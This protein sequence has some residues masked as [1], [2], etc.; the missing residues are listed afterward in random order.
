MVEPE[1]AFADLNTAA[2]LAEDLL[3]YC[4]QAVLNEREDD[5]DFF[6]KR[7][8]SD[9]KKRL[10]KFVDSDFIQVDYT[11]AIKILIDSGE[12]FSFPVEWGVD[13]QSEHERYLA[14]THFQAPVI[15]KNYPKGIKSFYMRLNEDGK[16]VAAMDV[17]AP[18]IGEIIGGSQREERLEILDQRMHESGLDPEQYSLVPRSEKVWHSSSCWIWLRF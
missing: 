2:S 16:T 3:K 18:G 4:F 5:L 11:D 10:K 15:V 1:I 9:V 12:A 13:L 6:E 7:V 14:E 17:L 8:N